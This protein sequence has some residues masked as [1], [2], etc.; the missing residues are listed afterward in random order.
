MSAEGALEE[1]L[2]PAERARAEAS[3]RVRQAQSHG[4]AYSTLTLTLY[5][6]APVALPWATC[7]T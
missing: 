4:A 1:D 7:S 3:M 6:E 5:F 2:A